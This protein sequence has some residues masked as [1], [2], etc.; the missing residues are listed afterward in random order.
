MHSSRS[1][2][3]GFFRPPRP[4]S[5][6]HPSGIFGYAVRHRP[7]QCFNISPRSKARAPVLRAAVCA[8]PLQHIEVFAYRRPGARC[9]VPWA[10]GRACPLQHIEVSILCRTRARSL[11]PRA[12]VRARPMQHLEVPATCCTHA[13]VYVPRAVVRAQHRQLFE[14]SAP[15]RCVTKVFLTR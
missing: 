14:L 11:V 10:A 3:D 4:F 7:L 6:C 13:R 15:R 5:P 12:A 1:N 2:R 9:L 8:R